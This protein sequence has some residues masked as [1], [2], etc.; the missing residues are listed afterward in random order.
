M[1][2]IEASVPVTDQDGRMY[3][4]NLFRDLEVLMLAYSTG[5]RKTVSDGVW[6]SEDGMLMIDQIMMY[7][8]TISDP[9]IALQLRTEIAKYII[10]QLKQDEAY[11]LVYKL[12]PLMLQGIY[13]P[14]NQTD[15]LT[16]PCGV[17][18]WMRDL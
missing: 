1:Y 10:E 8:I 17:A 18:S 16:I 15:D 4:Q 6:Y 13:E 2:R 9:I 3:P 5:F 12:E 14:V 7:T 11:I